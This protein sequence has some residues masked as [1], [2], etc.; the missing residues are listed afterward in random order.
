VACQF[1]YKSYG[2]DTN[3]IFKILDVAEAS[4]TFIGTDVPSKI[5]FGTI[6]WFFHLV[7]D[8]AGSSGSA[9]L[10]G[11][12]GIPGPLLALAKEFSVLP[13]FKDINIGDKSLSEFLA[14]LFN[15]TLFAKK[16]ESG[17]IIRDSVLKF[18]LRGELGVGI[19]DEVKP[20]NNP[21][22]ARMLTIAT[23][24]FT[25]VDVGEAVLSQKYWLSVSYVGVGRFAVAIGEDVSWCLKARK[26]KL[27]KQ[28]YEDIKRFAYTQEDDKLYERIGIDMN[29]DKLGLTVEQMEI[30][31]NLEYCQ[32]PTARRRWLAKTAE[33]R[34]K[35]P[36]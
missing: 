16:D 10:S 18:D 34:L 27:I 11:G 31:Y 14:K 24:V 6:T 19:E 30:L 1:T 2:T 32:P 25:A 22:I 23:G 12:T 17:K 5:F 21:T 26:V 7:S 33:S 20:S 36:S 28:M 15:G 13:F 9:G 3:G 4:K 8:V 29:N 35:Q